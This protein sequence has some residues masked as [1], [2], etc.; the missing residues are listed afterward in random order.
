MVVT[1][2]QSAFPRQP[3]HSDDA[4]LGGQAS[5]AV[6]SG[7]VELPS[8]REVGMTAYMRAYRALRGRGPVSRQD[9]LDETFIDR[10]PGHCRRCSDSTNEAL[11]VLC[12]RELAS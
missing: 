7:P 5:A 1:G 12:L 9:W 8:P 4:G 3:S 11:C 6:A 10:R 2:P